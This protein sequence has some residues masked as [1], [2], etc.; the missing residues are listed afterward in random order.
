VISYNQI[1]K[2]FDVDTDFDSV[3]VENFLPIYEFSQLQN[4][5]LSD[6]SKENVP[7]D[8]GLGRYSVG[9]DLSSLECI[10]IAAKRVTEIMGEEYVCSGHYSV[11]YQIKDGNVPMLYNHRDTQGGNITV[12]LVVD[13]TIIPASLS[14]SL[15][16]SLTVSL[17]TSRIIDFISLILKLDMTKSI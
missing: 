3:E 6:Y 5:L 15:T 17:T 10:D 2:L 14:S 11:K 1:E 12:D 7:Y 4:V 13:S 9:H 8:K 16:T